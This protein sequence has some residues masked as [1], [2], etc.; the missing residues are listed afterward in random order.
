M[1]RSVLLIAAAAVLLPRAASAFE[2]FCKMYEKPGFKGRSI[3]LESDKFFDFSDDPAWNDRVSSVQIGNECQ[4]SVTEDMTGK[5][6]S[7][8]YF[9]D[10]P[11]LGF[12]NDRITAGGCYCAD[13]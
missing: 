2:Q 10:Q 7:A 13:D 8:D 9:A 6:E 4:L 12:W 1:P 5:R 11:E 3:R